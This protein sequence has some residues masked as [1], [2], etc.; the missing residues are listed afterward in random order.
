MASKKGE[1]G[2]SFE[3]YFKRALN[4]LVILSLLQ[5]RPKYAYEM[6]QELRSRTDGGYT[7]PLLYPVL[8]RLE[9]QGYIEQSTKVISENNRVRNYYRITSA[10]VEHLKQIKAEYVRLCG[11]VRQ[12]V[13]LPEEP[14]LDT[15]AQ[16]R[17]R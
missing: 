5:E 2:H 17:K 14:C 3:D 6:T 8:Y 10:G 13:D 15:C 7:M 11:N 12:L 16:G 4:P 9:E 1:Y